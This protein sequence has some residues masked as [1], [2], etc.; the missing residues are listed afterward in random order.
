MTIAM[1]DLHHILLFNVRCIVSFLCIPIYENNIRKYLKLG[2]LLTIYSNMMW[3][4]IEFHKLPLGNYPY[5]GI[6]LIKD[7][8]ETIKLFQWNFSS[9]SKL[10]DGILEDFHW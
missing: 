3:L 1:I 2:I 6:P 5:Y 7:T 10:Q 8:L 4:V 9:V